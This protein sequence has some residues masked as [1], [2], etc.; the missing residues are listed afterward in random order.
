MELVTEKIEFATIRVKVYGMD[1]EGRPFFESATVLRPTL[2]TALLEGMK[3]R[4]K[5]GEVLGVQYNGRKARALVI[6]GCEAEQLKNQ[7]GIQ[8][9]TPESCPW[10]EHA[11]PAA[12]RKD[13][14]GR[15][16]RKHVR[17]KL[18]VALDLEELASRVKM[19]AQ[20]TD[21][22]LSGCYVHT[23]LPLPVGTTLTAGVWLG[24]ERIAVT[25]LVRTCDGQV[26]MGIEFMNLTAEQESR[27]QQFLQSATS[28][29]VSGVR[30]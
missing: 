29:S 5:S 30:S 15:E 23:M 1:T 3:H 7:M 21:I 13:G 14:L 26:G 17:H 25:A 4:L 10:P 28:P 12:Q 19:Q 18:N 6:S 9:L 2:Q 22:S 27:L 16:R 11:A 20:C 24:N 8:L